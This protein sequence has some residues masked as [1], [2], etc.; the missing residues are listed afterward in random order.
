METEL[1]TGALVPSSSA[2]SAAALGIG[3]AGGSK[4]VRSRTA[5]AATTGMGAGGRGE[6]AGAGPGGE[7]GDV[8]K[9]HSGL[10]SE[11]DDSRGRSRGAKVGVDWICTSAVRCFSRG[12]AV[13]VVFLPP[14]CSK[15]S[16]KTVCSKLME[17]SYLE[18][19]LCCIIVLNDRLPM[20]TP[21]ATNVARARCAS[22]R[23]GLIAAADARDVPRMNPL[24]PRMN[25]P[26]FLVGCRGS[27][28]TSITATSPGRSAERQQFSDILPCSSTP[29]FT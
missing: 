29:A 1:H 20:P 14:T 15:R 17:P 24:Q 27:A 3:R 5:G 25:R 28:P 9:H 11:A 13:V 4:G 6:G 7:A 16:I 26:Y 2:A 19:F 12:C 8:G 18:I 10:L 22:I 21:L 23:V